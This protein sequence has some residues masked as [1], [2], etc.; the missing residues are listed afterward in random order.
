MLPDR[1][2]RLLTAYI[3]GELDAQQHKVV[4]RLLRRSS[5]ARE[6]VKQLQSDTEQVRSLPCQPLS[7]E[8]SQ[9]VLQALASHKAEAVRRSALTNSSLRPLWLGLATAAAVLLTIG[10][11]SY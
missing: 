8:F 11:G 3:D 1:I 5:E 2:T 6:L 9:Q 10:L 7:P 4:L